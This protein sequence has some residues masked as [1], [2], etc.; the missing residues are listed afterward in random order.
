MTPFKL[1]KRNSGIA[2]SRRRLERNSILARAA[3]P[4]SELGFS[5]GRMM[6]KKSAIAMA[7][8]AFLV[9]APGMKAA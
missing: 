1:E 6:N 7:T 5:R 4:N 3:G 9:F 8:F 2:D